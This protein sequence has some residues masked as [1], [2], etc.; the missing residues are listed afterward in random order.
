MIAGISVC[1]ALQAIS[2]EAAEEIRLSLWDE[3]E[4]L[5]TKLNTEV[6]QEEIIILKVLQTQCLK[7]NLFHR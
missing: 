7:I 3:L 4:L 1:E 2:N 5:E 6:L